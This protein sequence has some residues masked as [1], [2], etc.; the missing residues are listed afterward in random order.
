MI[1]L[2]VRRD[3]RSGMRPGV[4]CV[5]RV[6]HEISRTLSMHRLTVEGVI[7][8]WAHFKQVAV[9]R[10]YRASTEHLRGSLPRIFIA[11]D[12]MQLEQL[13]ARACGEPS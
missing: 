5:Q 11:L 8:Q 12:V 1:E 13:D 3:E 4:T 7:G 2:L 10:D 9:C 6:R